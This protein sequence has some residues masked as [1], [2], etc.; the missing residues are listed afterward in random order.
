MPE[1]IVLSAPVYPHPNE[2]AYGLGEWE[3]SVSYSN[4]VHGGPSFTDHEYRVV[5]IPGFDVPGVRL[6]LFLP[7][8]FTK[9]SFL[10]AFKLGTLADAAW[11]CRTDGSVAWHPMKEEETEP[12]G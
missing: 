10:R 12:C 8:D 6:W 3:P 4:L 11:W 9:H 5:Q 2:G 7:L 1:Q